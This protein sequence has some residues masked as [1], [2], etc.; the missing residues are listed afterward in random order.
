MVARV[1]AQR[2]QKLG[3]EKNLGSQFK[4]RLA[5]LDPTGVNPSAPGYVGSLAYAG[6]E[7]G[8]ASYGA[9]YPERD[10][11]GGFAP[12][13]GATYALNP[14]TLVRAG[15]GLF[16][17]RAFIPGWGHMTNPVLRGISGETPEGGPAC[18]D[19]TCAL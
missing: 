3:M 9:R 18:A 1:I 12:R 6:N 13:L 4:D 7:W 16:Y 11:Y 17:D 10:W 19:G 15:W 5:F 14:Q 2:L 8:A